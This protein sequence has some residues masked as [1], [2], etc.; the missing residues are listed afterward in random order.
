MGKIEIYKTKDGQTEVEVKFDRDTVW[1][2]QKQIA[3]VFGTEVPAITKHIKNIFKSKE[4]NAQATISKMETVRKEGKRKVRRTVEY[5]S[6]DMIISIGYRVNSNRATQFRI[7]A[8]K[9][10]K[11][12][13]VKG[14]TL[15][16]KRLI[17][18]VQNL[19]ELEQAVKLIQQSGSSEELR[20]SEV[21]GLLEI[22]TNYTKSFVILNQ[23][24]SNQLSV[25]QLNTNITYEIKYDEA[26]AAIEE[27]R[28]QLINKKEAG[29][30]FGNQKDQ[31]FGGILL[32]IVQTFDGAYLYPSI[33][34]QAAHLLYFIIKNHAF[35]D[36]NKRIGAFLFIW[37]LEKNKHRFKKS[38]EVKI[39]DNA[40][41]ALA[42]L[43][44]QSNPS[45]KELM[46]KLIINLIKN[47]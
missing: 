33:E 27:L 45:E 40:L 39:N 37:F 4:L 32:N 41:T 11:E 30:L 36:G 18:L 1:L 23:Y 17:Q 3:E 35:S 28:K 5:Y 43:V 21:K 16:E 7:W 29:D 25:E 20:L 44:A 8:T 42:L 19:R 46:I 9:N 6:L 13:L 14:Y 31:S 15:N 38:G 47:N 2:T 10:V 12:Y 26:I 34:E 22:I 24:D